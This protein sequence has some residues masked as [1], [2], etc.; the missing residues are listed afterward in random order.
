M[1]ECKLGVSLPADNMLSNS[2]HYV[3]LIFYRKTEIDEIVMT[4]MA[5]LEKKKEEK[6]SKDKQPKS[7]G[8]PSKR[9]HSDSDDDDNDDDDDD[10]DDEEEE[11]DVKEEKSSSDDDKDVK[12]NLNVCIFEVL[13][14]IIWGTNTNQFI[15]C[16]NQFAQGTQFANK[17]VSFCPHSFRINLRLSVCG[18]CDLLFF[19][20]WYDN[21]TFE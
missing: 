20:G 10:N 6:K 18:A 4:E 19:A 5:N 13:N 14:T 11:D 2:C 17:C 8:K 7:N 21:M 9:K 3:L 1:F 15:S 16:L 12:P